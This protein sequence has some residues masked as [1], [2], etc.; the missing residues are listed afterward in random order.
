MLGARFGPKS[1]RQSSQKT[2]FI[3]ER[4][5]GTRTKTSLEQKLTDTEQAARHRQNTLGK[6]DTGGDTG[7][8]NQ[9]RNRRA[10]RGRAGKQETR[11][12][13]QNKTG[14]TPDPN[15]TPPPS[16]PGTLNNYTQE[17]ACLQKHDGGVHS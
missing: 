8:N 14:N 17:L 4:Q 9:D 6:R 5:A 16:P 15:S 2:M 1:S 13:L 10:Q 11:Q 12:G 7:G 3:D